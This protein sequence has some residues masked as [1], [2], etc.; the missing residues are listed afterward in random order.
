[1]VYGKFVV[2]IQVE[3]GELLAQITPEPLQTSFLTNSGT[4]A[5]EA[6]LKLARKYTGRSKI[7][8]TERAFHGRTF[9]ALSVTWRELYRKPFEPLLPGVEFIPYND[10]G[11]ARAAL[12][13][14]VAAIIWSRS[15]EGGVHI[16]DDDYLPGLRRMRRAGA[17]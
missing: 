15:G 7:I 17:R 13:E 1:M 9:G 14:E 4:E 5:I 11:A 6:A 8:S 12:T 16:P 3:V 2:P 10:L